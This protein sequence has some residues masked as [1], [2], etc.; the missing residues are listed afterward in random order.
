MSIVI[1]IILILASIVLI[2]A[3]LMQEG[4]KQGL[5]AIGGA[6]ETFMGK[7]KA[8]GAEGK[9]LL[10]TKITAAVFV[11]LAIVAT[12]WNLRAWT[13]KYYDANGNEYY[14]AIGSV[15]ANDATYKNTIAQYEKEGTSE[16]QL[17]KNIVANTASFTRGADITYVTVPAKEGHSGEW[18]LAEKKDGKIVAKEGALPTKMPAANVLVMV[19]YTV[20]QYELTVVNPDDAEGES[21]TTGKLDYGTELNYE[22]LGYTAPQAEEGEYLLYSTSETAL[23]NP[24]LYNA[25]LPETMPASEDGATTYYA[26]LVKGNCVE[27]YEEKDGEFVEYYPTIMSSLEYNKLLATYYGY[28]TEDY[29]TAAEYKEIVENIGKDIENEEEKELEKDY[30]RPFVQ[31]GSHLHDAVAYD[32]PNVPEGKVGVWETENGKELKDLEEMGTERVKLYATYYDAVT[33]TFTEVKPE[34]AAED[35]ALAADKTVTGK[36][37]DAIT[38]DMLP[39]KEHAAV[40]WI[41]AV[42][43]TFPE[44]DATYTYKLIPDTKLTFTEKKAEGEEGEAKTETVY[45]QPG[46]ALTED[47]LPAYEGFEIEWNEAL[48]ETFPEADATYTFKL[49]PVEEKAE[50][51]VLTF[52]EKTPEDA[53]E[54]FEPKTFEITGKAG[55][56]IDANEWLRYE[57]FTGEAVEGE[58]LPEVFPEEAAEYSFTLKEIETEP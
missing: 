4:N 30:Y 33:L 28:D 16:A 5:G 7:S 58:T 9:L 53:G 45:G 39:S 23:D 6:A 57:G 31:E 44:A 41:D 29:D 26:Y 18:V 10:I 1:N 46:S 21:F 51:I 35:Y 12:W 20:N 25:K 3:V 27:F 15:E 32:V 54:D 50:D 11:V 36:A 17:K 52:T 49:N 24:A 13:V 19:K 55:E 37:G 47:M 14:P 34:G 48:P 40:E 43:E 42:P 38:E 56:A 8:K 2:V 22:E